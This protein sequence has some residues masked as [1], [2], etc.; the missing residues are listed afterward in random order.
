MEFSVAS[1]K[2][3]FAIDE[4]LILNAHIYIKPLEC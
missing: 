1:M 2:Y 4:R 3:T